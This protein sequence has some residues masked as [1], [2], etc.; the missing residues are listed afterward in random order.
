M[1]G[2]LKPSEIFSENGDPL[3][4]KFPSQRLSVLL[5]LC[6]CPLNSLREKST[7]IDLGKSP[8]PSGKSPFSWGGQV[9]VLLDPENISVEVFQ[10]RTQGPIAG[11]SGKSPGITG[12]LKIY[13]INSVHTSTPNVTGR[14]KR[15]IN[16]LK[17]GTTLGQPAG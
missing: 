10:V 6:I 7:E 17:V 16:F 3:K 15:H 14:R 8:L 9:W 2:L 11:L 13:I 1:R 12:N 4:G 5:P